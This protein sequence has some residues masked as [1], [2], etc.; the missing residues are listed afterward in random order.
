MVK[1]DYRED[2]DRLK[3]SEKNVMLPLEQ[4]ISKH[5]LE[6][7]RTA[8]EDVTSDT[9]EASESSSKEEKDQEESID[10][11]VRDNETQDFSDVDSEREHN[12]D[13]LRARLANFPDEHSGKIRSSLKE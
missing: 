8:C 4:D 5:R 12:M 1:L 10:I 13:L 2:V 7:S 3:M 11:S 6:N 9:G